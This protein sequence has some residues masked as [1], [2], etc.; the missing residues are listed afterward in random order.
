MNCGEY[1]RETKNPYTQQTSTYQSQPISYVNTI[2][3]GYTIKNN[4]NI[5]GY[6]QW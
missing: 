2:S 5:G 6:K 1:N 3:N 4:Y